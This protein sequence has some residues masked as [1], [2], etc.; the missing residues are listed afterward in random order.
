MADML[1]ETQIDELARIVAERK[2]ITV[3]EAAKLLKT[4]ESQIEEWVRILE[5]YGFVELIY[6]ALGEPQIILKEINQKDLTKKKKDLETRKEVVEEKTK[7]FQKKVDNAEKKIKISNKEFSELE[8][9]LKSKL[10]ELDK[11]LKVV[12]KL[13]GTKEEITKKSDEIKNVADSVSKEIE[14]IKEEIYQMESKINEHI[15]S[16]EEHET[17]IKDMD[18]DKKVIENEIMNLEKEIK[19]VKLLLNKPIKVSVINLKNIFSKHKERSEKISEKRRELH[20]KTLKM[21]SVISNKKKETKHKNFFSL[22][23][24]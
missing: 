7:D 22:F 18:E 6:P 21:K 14:G 19:I 20:Q 3:R 17:N 23:K 2:K 13:E 5:E 10:S 16:M 8:G 9:D 1:I 15:K 24:K 11:N 4:S 12:N